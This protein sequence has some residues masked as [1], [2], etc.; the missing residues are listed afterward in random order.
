MVLSA[1]AV[2]SSLLLLCRILLFS[3]TSVYLFSYFED[4][5][6]VQ[7]EAVMNDAL[8]QIKV[9]RDCGCIL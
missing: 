7:L 2:G 4:L 5:R 3:L 6:Y 9:S 8:F 1:M